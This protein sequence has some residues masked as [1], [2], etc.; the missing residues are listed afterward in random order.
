MQ[1]A[2]VV[3]TREGGWSAPFPDWDSPN[4][5]VLAFCG[6]DFI[7]DHDP[8]AELTSHFR[9]SSILGGSTYGEIAGSR[10]E[11]DSIV[12]AMARFDTTTVHL[13]ATELSAADPREAAAQAT[14][15]VT[16]AAHGQLGAILAM[17]GTGEVSGSHIV[18]GVNSVLQ[19]SVPVIGAAMGG[20]RSLR[21]AWVLVDGKPREDAMVAVGLRG[22]ELDFSHGA[23]AGWD[24]F[25][26]QRVVTRAEGNRLFELDGDSALELYRH[27]L[28]VHAESLPGAGLHFPLEVRDGTNGRSLVRSLMGIDEATGAIV[29]VGDVTEGSTVRLLRS[30]RERLTAAAV[31]AAHF[32]AVGGGGGSARLS[33]VFAGAS[34]RQVMASRI[35]DEVEAI[36]DAL[37]PNT[38]TVG[39]YS[40]GE[41]TTD[42]SGAC[43]LESAGVA[44]ATLG[45]SS[46]EDGVALL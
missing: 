33:V 4:T 29:L 9:R 36:D 6:Y 22:P 43:R 27:Y 41:L 8:I 7:D 10:V 16:H 3:F 34:R 30:S 42:G 26:P 28:G 31:D 12:V 1:V 20:G 5:L 38:Q 32:A 46:A 14:E 35:V 19:G 21:P 11:D 37:G 24:P 44:V 39:C 18:A 25:G 17:V 23:K 2:T 40:F 13:A 15:T 45:E